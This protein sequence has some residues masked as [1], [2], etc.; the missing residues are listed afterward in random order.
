MLLVPEFKVNL[1]SLYK[2]LEK[3]AT[4]KFTLRESLLYKNSTV[5]A[6]GDY[7]KKIATFSTYS[8]TGSQRV[9]QALSSTS[10]KDID[11]TTLVHKRLGHIGANSLYKLLENTQGLDLKLDTSKDLSNCVV[12]LQSK[13]AS[14]ISRNPVTT[15]VEDFG[16][17]IYIDLGGPIKPKTNRGYRYYIIFLDYKTKYLEVELLTSRA[18][19]INPIKAFTNRVEV[20]DNKRLKLIQADNE[21]STKELELLAKDKGFIFRFTPPFNPKAKGGGERINRTLFDKI[22]ALLI[23]SKLPKRLWAEALMSALYLYNRTPH[24]QTP[25]FLGE[26]KVDFHRFFCLILSQMPSWTCF[27]TSLL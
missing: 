6:R 5:L 20:Q 17:L 11:P 9:E 23:E 8:N 24:N 15:K 26:R 4:L 22:R 27:P 2:A 16:D 10:T 12:C 25:T 21:L 18:E 14:T 7:T 19:L 3:G 13:L 1:L